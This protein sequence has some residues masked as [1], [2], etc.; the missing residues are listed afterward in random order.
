MDCQATIDAGNG[1]ESLEGFTV[2]VVAT[3]PLPEGKARRREA[4]VRAWLSDNGEGRERTLESHR[5]RREKRLRQ[6][7][8]RL[9][10]ELQTL[11]G[12]GELK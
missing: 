8:A 7:V 4:L 12:G 11:E 10:Q 3:E 6:Q 1:C 9:Q 2:E 5:G